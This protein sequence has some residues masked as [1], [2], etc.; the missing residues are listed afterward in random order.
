MNKN[1]EIRAAES[2]LNACEVL[3]VLISFI[4]KINEQRVILTA[5][6]KMIGSEKHWNSGTGVCI[7][8]IDE[9]HSIIEQIETLFKKGLNQ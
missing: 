6:T 3:D 4:T 2:L 8:D 7:V 9:I 5:P 1:N